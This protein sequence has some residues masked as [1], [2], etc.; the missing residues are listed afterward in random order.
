V[1]YRAL[2]NKVKEENYVLLPGIDH[3]LCG[4]LSVSVVTVLPESSRSTSSR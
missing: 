1:E 3:R 2:S 4:G